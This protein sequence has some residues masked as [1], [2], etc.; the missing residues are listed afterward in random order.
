MNKNF[1][2]LFFPKSGKWKLEAS[3]DDRPHGFVFV[4][5][6]KRDE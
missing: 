2:L 5:V 4:H 3:I 1:Y 6:Y